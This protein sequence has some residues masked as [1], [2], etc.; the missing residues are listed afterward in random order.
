MDRACLRQR[1]PLTREVIGLRCDYLPRPAQ[2]GIFNPERSLSV[3]FIAVPPPSA[4]LMWYAQ[5]HETA[6]LYCLQ[7]RGLT[8][9]GCPTGLLGWWRRFQWQKEW[10]DKII[11]YKK[12]KPGR[13]LLGVTHTERKSLVRGRREA[14]E[15]WEE[16]CMLYWD[17]WTCGE[18]HVEVWF[19]G[20]FAV[21]V[22]SF[23]FL[24]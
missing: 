8:V 7:R 13:G 4:A 12:A 9:R 5:K 22:F 16:R 10:A 1:Y 23:L 14:E 17:D 3:R 2:T 15:T 24:F 11:L 19:W 20:H 21:S 6:S 18:R